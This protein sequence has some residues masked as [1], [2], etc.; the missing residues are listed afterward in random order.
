MLNSTLSHAMRVS[1]SGLTAERFRMDIISSNLANANSIKI[2]G[3]D[4]YRRQDVALAGDRNG[5]RITRIVPDQ[6]PFREVVDPGNPY[7]DAKGK[8]TQSNVDPLVEMV[9]MISASRS[10]E[11]NIAAF[12]SSKTM[13]R[14]A[15]SIG[16]I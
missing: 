7:A 12:N 2:N 10:Y 8:V 6:T 1:A 14:S 16:K 4:P 3:Q 11:A 13:M 15:L 9:N 5:V